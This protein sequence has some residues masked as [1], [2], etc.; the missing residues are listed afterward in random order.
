MERNFGAILD[1]AARSGVSQWNASSLIT[2]SA[3]L[4]TLDKGD[5]RLQ[6]TAT[7]NPG[8][9][10]MNFAR[11]LFVT[12][13]LAVVALVT[14]LTSQAQT[15]RKSSSGTVTV[16]D[17][18]TLKFKSYGVSTRTS[19]NRQSTTVFDYQNPGFKSYDVTTSGSGRSKTVSVFDYQ[20][21]GYKTYGVSTTG[22]GRSKT[23]TVFDY[24][25]PGFKS[26]G[27]SSSG[28]INPGIVIP[29]TDPE[30]EDEDRIGT[31]A[32]IYVPYGTTKEKKKQDSW[33]VDADE[34][35]GD[36]NDSYLDDDDGEES[37]DDDP[38]R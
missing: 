18:Q 20:N 4:Y 14:P 21:P 6:I 37:D 9:A 11:V 26:Y 35:D 36:D 19:G 24:Q 38:W 30:D 16:F 23:V 10:C 1:A 25:N 8:E 22:S 2:S 28:N 29:L 31:S 5:C 34:D 17:Y 32:R 3:R 15:E 13:C 12:M 7:I 33:R 27:V